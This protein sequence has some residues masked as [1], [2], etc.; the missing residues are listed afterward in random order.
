MYGIVSYIV[1]DFAVC[2]QTGRNFYYRAS[3]SPNERANNR[4]CDYPFENLLSYD[5]NSC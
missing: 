4:A 1:I 2:M 3:S 5:S